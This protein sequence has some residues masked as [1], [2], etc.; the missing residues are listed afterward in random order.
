[1]NIE[2]NNVTKFSQIIAIVVYVATF[3]FAF[4]LGMHASS[5]LDED[6][7]GN[8]LVR[9]IEIDEMGGNDATELVACTSDAKLWPDGSSVGR[10]GPSCEFA[11]CP[12]EEEGEPSEPAIMNEGEEFRPE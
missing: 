6:V 12:G 4:W 11:P 3:V 9:E 5:V 8:V 10:V 7:E 2:W 1:M